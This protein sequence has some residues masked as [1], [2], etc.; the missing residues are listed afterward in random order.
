VT[1]TEVGLIMTALG[2]R[3]A[4]VCDVPSERDYEQRRQTYIDRSTVL[5]SVTRCLG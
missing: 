3:G 4:R 5:R 1:P 2:E